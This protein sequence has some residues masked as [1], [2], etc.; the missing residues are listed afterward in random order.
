MEGA[1]R[2]SPDTPRPPGLW[3]GGVLVGADEGPKGKALA[4]S[5]RAL[6]EAPL[7]CRRC[8]CRATTSRTGCGCR[9]PAAAGR[10]RV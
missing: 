9:L 6:T 1:E 8:A 10:G 7:S 5:P 3:N 2:L 4:C